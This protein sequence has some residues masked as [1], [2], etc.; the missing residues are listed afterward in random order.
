MT[1]LSPRE[2]SMAIPWWAGLVQG[3]LSILI[4]ILLLTYPAATTAVIVQFVGIY[5]LINGIFLLVGIFADKT[6][7]G[8][9]LIAGI[10]G[11]LAGLSIIQHP[12]WST[13]LLPAV[14]VIFL[15][16]DGLIIGVV[17]LIA[18]FKGGGWAMGILG[19]VSILFGL[20]LLGSP[21]IAAFSFPLIY[22]IFGI[23]GG[24]GAIFAAFRR[25]NVTRDQN[26]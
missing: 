17:S 11:I 16:V 21:L 10:L 20:L 9:K 7:W 14:L 1:T 6:L 18:A 8:L 13:I 25:K 4:G 2:N 12:L 22:G 15:G 3:I 5:W 19:G 24:I 23:V 26:M